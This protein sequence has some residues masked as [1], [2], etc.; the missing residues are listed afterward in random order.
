[1]SNMDLSRQGHGDISKILC[2]AHL[3][4]AV[5]VHTVAIALII[6]MQ[7]WKIDGGK[8]NAV[9]GCPPTIRRE[10]MTFVEFIDFSQGFHDS[11]PRF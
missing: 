11:F 7:K 2:Q 6:S 5:F 8:C 10:S 3:K 9:N 4:K 1:M